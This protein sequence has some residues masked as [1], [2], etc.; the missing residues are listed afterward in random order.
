VKGE[1][2]RSEKVKLQGRKEPF[3]KTDYSAAGAGFWFGRA[4]S[5]RRPAVGI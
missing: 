4:L 5:E 3:L 1:K 2:D